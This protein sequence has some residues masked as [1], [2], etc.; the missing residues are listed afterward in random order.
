MMFITLNFLVI[1]FLIS[2][3]GK[4]AVAAFG[5]STRIVQVMLLPT[6]GLNI[7]ALSLTGFNFGAGDLG[8][9]KEIWR[10]CM[11][12]AFLMMCVGAVILFVTLKLWLGLFTQSPEILDIG[13]GLLRVEAVLLPAYTTLFLGVA[14]LQGLKKPMFGMILGCYRLIIAPVI[15][16]W[17]FL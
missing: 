13:E 3:L 15:L 16:F 10:T 6:I 17:F 5:V 12:I 4:S 14:V 11:R 8:R 1:L 2:D 9:V 7:A